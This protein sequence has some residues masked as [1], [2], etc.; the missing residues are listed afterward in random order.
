MLPGDTAAIR[1]RVRLAR[2]GTFTNTGIKAAAA[3]RQEERSASTATRVT[4]R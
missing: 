3:E 2:L 1:V 4:R